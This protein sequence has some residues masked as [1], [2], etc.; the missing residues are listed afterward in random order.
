MKCVAPVRTFRVILIVLLIV[1]LIACTT[2][3]VT[4]GSPELSA[5]N[6]KAY[7]TRSTVFLR[8]G[9]RLVIDRLQVGADLAQGE[10]VKPKVDRLPTSA[11]QAWRKPDAASALVEIDSNAIDRVVF[12]TARGK[13][14]LIGALAGLV[15]GGG[16]GAGIGAAVADDQFCVG[17]ADACND[18]GDELGALIVGVIG[19][20]TLAVVGALIGLHGLERT[21]LI[22][23]AP[24][25]PAFV[26]MPTPEAA[27]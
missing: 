6:V 14:S 1:D 9:A 24:G 21:Y 13:G 18:S 20:A 23:P 8:D 22:E 25:P 5:M 2:R 17:S 19:A 11:E 4:L 3:T 10:L 12:T 26:P 7:R 16:I 27:K 15:L